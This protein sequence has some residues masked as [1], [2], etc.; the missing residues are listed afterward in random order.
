[1]E[2]SDPNSFR[3]S[4]GSGYS[5]RCV[6]RQYRQRHLTSRRWNGKTVTNSRASW[7]HQ[8][9]SPLSRQRSCFGMLWSSYR[10]PLADDHCRPQRCRQQHDRRG[11]ETQPRGRARN[12][13]N[14][15]SPSVLS[16]WTNHMEIDHFDQRCPVCLSC[17][18]FLRRFPCGAAV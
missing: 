4:V 14:Y 9:T 1:M 13:R 17:C 2:H 6:Q 16:Q 12:A 7:S 8:P 10:R 15:L 5:Q 18:Q 11:H 3:T